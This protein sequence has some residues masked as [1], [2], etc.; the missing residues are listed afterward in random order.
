MYTVV[1]PYSWFHFLWFQLHVVNCGLKILNGKF[2]KLY[3]IRFHLHAALSCMMK[4]HA[5]RL[6]LAQ[7][8]NH[9]FV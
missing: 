5:V 3:S 2:Q 8:M 9:L 4:V 7:D 1:S 6:H